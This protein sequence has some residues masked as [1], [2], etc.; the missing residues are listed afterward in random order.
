MEND[1]SVLD[2]KTC[3]NKYGG[4]TTSLSFPACVEEANEVNLSFIGVNMHRVEGHIKIA[5]I[6]VV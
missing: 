1:I 2:W 6:Y 5:A 4:A 3:F